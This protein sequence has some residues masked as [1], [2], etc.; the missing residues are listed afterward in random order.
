MMAEL[1]P[2][3][4]VVDLVERY[5]P[6]WEANRDDVDEID[7]WY[8]G[9]LV[10]QDKPVLS[11]RST[12]EYRELRDRSATRW[13]E[14]VVTTVA[15][16]LY[17]E[18]YRS[19][20]GDEGNARAWAAWQRNGLDA[21]QS[22][23]HRGALAHGLSYVTLTPGGVDR[24][25]IPTMRTVS[26]RKMMTWWADP[27]NDEW[28]MYAMTGE[29]VTSDTVRFVFYDQWG[30]Y[31]V[32]RKDDRF[33]FVT[34]EVHGFGEC[35]VVRFANQLDSDG[36]TVGEVEPHIDLAARINQDTFDRLIVQR[37]GAWLLRWVAGMELADPDLDPDADSKNR[38]L[39]AKI[40]VEDILLIDSPDAKL[41]AFPATPLGGYID[42][43]DADIRD[44]AAVTQTP[45][46]H[47]LGH[48]ANLSAE[49][50]AA[51]E[52][53]LTRKVSERKHQYGESWEQVLRGAAH[54]MGDV[55]GAS[56][57]AAEVRWSDTE[58]RSLAQA[59]DALLKLAQIGV[60]LRLLLEKVPGFTQQD[61]DMAIAEM[62]DA[63]AMNDLAAKIEG[64]LRGDS[65]AG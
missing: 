1:M 28:P 31:T 34:S 38:A 48:V 57:F 46:H 64:S 45:P 11:G 20:A 56:D 22:R 8:R 43:R 3:G 23:V 62:N 51:A 65:D 7:R 37:F 32:D 18:G 26:A 36:R 53:G 25:F 49:A 21:R 5:S 14:L 17:V 12:R 16:S 39:K 58:S 19:S 15:Q 29:R 35:P 6:E 63:S 33:V 44:L 47:L 24:E 50:L 2:R 54:L 40:A 42:S 60:P 4:N 13:L 61:I 27:A 55:E 9:A 41:G 59:A 10:E 30:R 52:A